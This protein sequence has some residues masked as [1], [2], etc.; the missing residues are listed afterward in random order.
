[1]TAIHITAAHPVVADEAGE[2][3]PARDARLTLRLNAIAAWL[4]PGMVTVGMAFGAP[5]N[6]SLLRAR[7]QALSTGRGRRL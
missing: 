7:S 1:M 2:P 5:V 4:A 6:A 3:E